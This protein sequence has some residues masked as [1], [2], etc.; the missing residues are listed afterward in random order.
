MDELAIAA[1]DLLHR[2]SSAP[3]QYKRIQTVSLSRIH[4]WHILGILAV[5]LT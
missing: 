2:D 5:W 4:S 3:R 1:S